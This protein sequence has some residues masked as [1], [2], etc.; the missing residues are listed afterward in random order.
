MTPAQTWWRTA[1][2]YQVWPRSFAD[3]GGD[4]VG[5]IRGVIDHLDHLADL[6]VDAVWLSPVY[7][8]PG[9]DGGYDVSDY[10][11]VDPLF[12]S[13]ADL[14]GLIAGL[15][16][17]GMRLVMDMVLNH[18]SDQHPWFSE[19]PAF[20]VFRDQPANDWSSVF[21]GPAWEARD[22]RYYLHTFAREQP[23]LDWENPA[24]RT[25]IHDLL[26]WWLERGVDGFRF[27]VISMVSKDLEHGTPLGFGPRL[28]EFL[29]EVHGVTGEVMTVG[30]MPGVTVEQADLVT[31]PARDELDMV[32]TFEHVGLD[33]GVTKWDHRP[34]HLPVLKACMARWQAMP[35]G[36][37]SLY[38]SNHDQPRSVSRFGDDGQHRVAS[39]KALATT[40]H[41]HRGTPFVY[42][43]EELG[44][45]NAHFAA[46]KDYRDVES[47]RYADEAREQGQESDAIL[48]ALGRTSR[49]NARTPMLWNDGPQRGFTTGEPWIPLP[50]STVPGAAE[51]RT[52]PSS[53]LAHY[54]A[55]I[56]LRHSE[57]AVAH[58]DFRLL[59]GEDVRL[60]AF[61]RT[62]EDQTLLVVANWSVDT[63][64]PD[65]DQTGELLLGPPGTTLGPW[66]SRVVR[67]G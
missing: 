66:E 60:W 49:D 41:L 26:G 32:F 11:D 61:T 12:G 15:H 48:E 43:G 65:L 47:L 6:G 54:R 64:E 23:D 27:D 21:S 5:D 10:Q 31:D 46:L 35:H 37:N 1:V 29:H 3:S 20:Y 39:A 4:G 38:W 62:Y 40:L 16:E 2:V 63:I 52:D 33:Q 50:V 28:H 44:M 36:W 22:A 42:Q 30:E 14:D 59:L 13:L 18:T 45:T 51:Q 19:H 17:R 56:A 53:V 9:V 8:S 55:L 34:L 25:K 7:P 67:T 57:P 58:G 24:V